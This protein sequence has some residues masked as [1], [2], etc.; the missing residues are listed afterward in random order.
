M[1]FA[2]IGAGL[3]IVWGL[4]HIKAAYDQFLLSASLDPGLIHGKLNQGAWDLLCFALASIV[5]A[6]VLNWKNDATGY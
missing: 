1:K 2:K 6:V 4:L 5:I 3:Y